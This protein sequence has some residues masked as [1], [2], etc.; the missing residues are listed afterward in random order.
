M[1]GLLDGGAVETT[2][3]GTYPASV[4]FASMIGRTAVVSVVALSLVACSDDG[5]AE[6]AT[7][8]PTTTGDG[9]GSTST[10]L[11]DDVRAV[12]DA[13]GCDD[14]TAGVA[15]QFAGR[16]QEFICRDDGTTVGLIHSFNNDLRDNV[17][18]YLGVRLDSD[19]LNPCP[20]G[21]R[22]IAGPWIV[23]G[24]TWAASSFDEDRIRNVASEVGG[25]FVGGG[26]TP[27]DPP[28]GPPPSY[29]VPGFCDR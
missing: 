12:A 20:D 5:G 10:S 3:R 11:P 29:D 24:P 15:F 23:V 21:S 1:L 8:E 7:D 4:A 19:Q 14:L 25:A 18:T 28:I 2:T 27:A 16:S 13:V 6:S 26:A 17:T 9:A 22:P